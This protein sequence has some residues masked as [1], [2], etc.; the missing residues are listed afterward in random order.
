MLQHV[1]VGRGDLLG[2]DARH[3]GDDRLDFLDVDALLALTLRQQALACTGLVDHVDGLVRQQAVTDMLDRQVHCRAQSVIGVG[4]AMVRLVLATQALEDFIGLAHRRLD[5]V[6]LLEATGQRTVFLEDAAVFL[7]GGRADAAQLAR[8][9][10]RLDQVGRIHGATRRRAGPD[11]GVDLVDEQHRVGDLLQRSDHALQALLEITAV[12]GAGNQRA[13]VQRVDHRIGQYFRHLAVDDA[14]GQA[15]G[16]GSLAHAGLAHVQRIVLAAAAQDLDGPF[17]LVTTTNQRVDTAGLGR[18]V[19]VAGEL[20]QGIALA[21]ALHALR[22]AFPIQR[23][24][25]VG[26]IA[27]VLAHAVG[28]VIDHVQ[29]GHILLVEVID[30]VGLLLAKDRHQHVGTGDLLLS[31]GLHVIDRPLQH[32]LEAQG[33]LG[34]AAVVFG[35]Q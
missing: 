29:P 24:G 23:R 30:R 4:D 1:L 28:Q 8:G 5:D 21:L 15:F 35:Q 16:N 9:Q 34:I 14:L 2:R 6:D 26:V 25:H 12:L 13:Q 18:L 33:G 31:R 27:T 22:T 10:R 3:L 17:D 19:E 20:G 32:P 7:E 11:D